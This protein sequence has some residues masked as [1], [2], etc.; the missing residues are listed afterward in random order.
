MIAEELKGNVIDLEGHDLVAVE[1]GHIDQGG[2][3]LGLL[4]GFVRTR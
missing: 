3:G 1:L 2:L 4:A